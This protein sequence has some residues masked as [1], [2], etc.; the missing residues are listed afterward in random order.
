MTAPDSSTR[1]SILAAADSAMEALVP[2]SFSRLGHDIRK[3]MWSWGPAVGDLTGATIVV[4]GATSGLGYETARELLGA[5]ATVDIVVRNRG[6]GDDAAARLAVDAG[7]APTVRVA[8]MGD[9]DAVL[10]LA[11]ELSAAHERID[12]LVHNAGAIETERR[13]TTDGIEATWA[14]MVVGPHLLT[15]A[16]DDRLATGRVVFVTSGGM[17]TQRLHLDD[18]NF[19]VGEFNGT[20]AY[21]RAK[22]AQ[23][24]LVAEYA[25][26][27]LPGP[28]SIVVAVHPGWADTPGVS[29][30][31]PLFHRV[32]GPVLRSPADGVDTV[33]WA[34]A[35]D[36]ELRDG[37]LYFDR[38]ERSVARLPR[39]A[40]SSADRRELWDL[41][42]RQ[43]RR[44]LV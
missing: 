3:R 20:V 32:M 37:A 4:T 33:L 9:L 29:G 5:G 42:E 19:A 21:A 35:G 34:V 17:Y 38:L 25:R 11:A 36:D 41:V 1:S 26:R 8:D 23:V 44:P 18:P 16:L 31:L 7:T 24:D 39:T 12:G 40:T 28:S 2:L 22:R 6:R 15:R 43:A 30:S 10:A 14:S 27:D 13:L